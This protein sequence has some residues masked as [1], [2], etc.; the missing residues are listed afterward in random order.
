[1]TS[2]RATLPRRRPHDVVAASHA[3]FDFTAGVGT[4]PDGR[5]GEVFVSIAKAGTPL[6][7]LGADAGVIV[8]IALQHGASIDDLRHSISRDETGQPQ[9]LIGAVLDLMAPPPTPEDDRDA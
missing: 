9:S 8:S 7:A 2:G 5:P 6:E 1:M 4:F 3:G